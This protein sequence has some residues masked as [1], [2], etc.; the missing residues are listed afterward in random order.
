MFVTPIPSKLTK[1]GLAHQGTPAVSERIGHTVG[2]DFLKP[3]AT[4]CLHLLDVPVPYSALP[5]DAML[6]KTLNGTQ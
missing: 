3:A 5:N 4:L 2:S 6:K 1:G